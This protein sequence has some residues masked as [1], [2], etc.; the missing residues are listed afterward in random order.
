MKLLRWIL[1]LALAAGLA[2]IAWWVLSPAKPAEVDTATVERGRLVSEL[3][4]NGKTEPAVWTSVPATRD[5]RVAEVLAEIGHA[6]SAGAPL[7]RI[8]TPE[9]QADLAAAEARVARARA[10]LAPA[11]QGGR[12]SEIVELDGALARLRGEREAALREEQALERLLAK[13]AATRLEFDAAADR[14][15]RLDTEIRT[16]E[17]KRKALVEPLDRSSAEATMEEATR[18]LAAVRSRLDAAVLKA[19]HAGVVY[20]LPVRPGDWLTAGMLVARIGVLDRLRVKVFVDEPELGGLALGQPVT[21]TWDALAKKEWLG[22]IERLPQQIVSLGSRQVGEVVS[23]V[24]NPGR[25]LPPGAN[26][27]ARIRTRTIDQAVSIPKEALR[28]EGDTYGVFVVRDGRVQWRAV[29]TGAASVTRL[30]IVSGLQPGETVALA[31][32]ETLR[33]GMAVRTAAAN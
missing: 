14:R 28:R 23:L 11:A 19:P 30:E 25:E 18:A 4:T 2:G 1:W 29:Q 20:E 13:N 31:G 21:V 24:E 5:G 32:E 6:V 3:A 10:A 7:L 27:N 26:V 16:N 15:K 22:A 33:D 8:A 17:S 12:T 9:A